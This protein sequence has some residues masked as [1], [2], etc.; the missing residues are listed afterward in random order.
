VE[1][2]GGDVVPG[3]SQEG[4][5][6]PALELSPPRRRGP[7]AV[8]PV[9]RALDPRLR[10]DDEPWLRREPLHHEAGLSSSHT[11]APP[12][13][14][15]VA[16]AQAGPQWC[17]PRLPIRSAIALLLVLLLAACA[18]DEPPALR[19]L[20]HEAYVWQRQWTPAVGAAVREHSADFRGL[21]VLV[22]QQIGDQRIE[23]RPDLDALR[24]RRLPLRLVLRIEGS[25]PRANAE[26]LARALGEIAQPWRAQGLQVEGVEVDHDCAAAALADYADWLRRFRAAAPSDLALSI[27]ALPSWL[28][29]PDGLRALREV[30]DETVLQVHAVE[31]WRS[32]LIDVES[33][34]RWARAWQAH[35]SRSFHVALPAYS[36]RV[37][38]GRDGTPAAVDAE[39]VLDRSGQGAQE[40]RADPAEVARL[41]RGLEAE[42]LPQLQGLLWFRLPVAGDRRSWAPSTLTAVLRGALP[43]AAIEL[44]AIERG[45]GLQDL[46]LRNAG[47][48]DAAAPARIALPAHC[49]LV[50]GV[51]PYAA[52]P[53]HTALQAESPPWLAPGAALAL[54][55]ARCEPALPTRQHLPVDAGDDGV[56]SP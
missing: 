11:D 31:A 41:V 24:D 35:A 43:P 30:A 39:G 8:A 40:R 7:R 20:E 38:L 55:F 54:G 51:G 56:R 37:Q 6:Q 19:T 3:C 12:L 18:A 53:G 27:T 44:H 42:R 50:E 14:R 36:L 4:E 47:E 32:A 46:L 26:A 17:A 5:R 25:R 22:L 10:G 45:P 13:S 23:V 48:I 16:P 33:S 49:T 52:E 9:A 2:A 15:S 29:A 21:R 1:D 34:L 28:E